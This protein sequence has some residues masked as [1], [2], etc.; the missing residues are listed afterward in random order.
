MD[1]PVELAL[2]VYVRKDQDPERAHSSELD[3]LFQLDT[4][5]DVH[6]DDVGVGRPEGFVVE[7]EGHLIGHL[8]TPS[9]IFIFFVALLLLLLLLLAF[10]LMGWYW[11]RVEMERIQPE[12]RGKPVHKPD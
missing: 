2:C 5:L 6:V 7:E 11:V 4:R 1:P 9:I 8:I 3:V 12:N 10:Q